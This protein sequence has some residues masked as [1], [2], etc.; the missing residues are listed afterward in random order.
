MVHL[1]PFS[2]Y[3][4]FY[5]AFIGFILAL[6]LLDLGVF[7]RKSHEV[8]IKEAT[9]WTIIWISIAG[10]FNIGLYFYA[11]HAF[12]IS[13][14]LQSIPGFNAAASAKEV[15]LAFFTGYLMEKAL[16][17]DNIFVFSII[18]S[19]FAIPK[20]YQ[21]RILFYGILGALGFRALFITFGSYVM[22]Y[23]LVVVLFGVFLVF[24]GIKMLFSHDT[25]MEPEKSLLLRVLGKIFRLHPKIE[26]NSFFIVKNGLRYATPLF[27]ALVLV[28]MS[29]ILFAVDSVPAIFAITSE[30][31]IVFTSN[32]LAILGLRSLYFLILGGLDKFRYIQYGLSGVLIFVGC[33]MAFLQ[34]LIPG[35]FPITWSLGIIVGCIG[36]SIVASLVIPVS[37]KTTNTPQE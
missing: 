19:Y 25:M 7:H 21:H 20:I 24:T 6:L 18:F 11:Q 4:W 37:E 10:I 36:T 35:G 34:D 28:E 31:L 30:P 14:R 1:F 12:A 8:S 29:D 2:D 23:H 16:A 15:A 13:E 3:W 5:L 26:G 17:I 9:I 27:L 33:K 32:I 22:A